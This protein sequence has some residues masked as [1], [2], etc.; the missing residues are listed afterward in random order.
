MPRDVYDK[1]RLPELEPTVICFELGENSTRYL[2]IVE[3]VPIRVG[4]HLIPVDFVVLEMGES[5]KQ[6]LILG[7]L[8]LK[9]VEATIDV[10]KGEIKVNING[11]RSAF[12]FSPRFEVCD[13]INDKYVPPHCRFSNEEPK[14]KEEPKKK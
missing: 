12:N 1:L 6:S 7:R 8:F 13:M 11:E 9:I 2:G 5:K 3:D 14:M 10:S 4:H